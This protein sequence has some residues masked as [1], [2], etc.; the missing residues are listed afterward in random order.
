MAELNKLI[1]RSIANELFIPQNYKVYPTLINN[2]LWGSLDN[3]SSLVDTGNIKKLNI[4]KV[5]GIHYNDEIKSIS[6][7]NNQTSFNTINALRN[8]SI[9]YTNVLS[10]IDTSLEYIPEH[11]HIL[12]QIENIERM[13]KEYSSKLNMINYLVDELFDVNYATNMYMVGKETRIYPV[14]NKLVSSD[15]RI[16]GYIKVEGADD[17][18]TLNLIF[19]GIPVRMRRTLTSEYPGGLKN[20]IFTYP[21]YMLDNIDLIQAIQYIEINDQGASASFWYGTT[22]DFTLTDFTGFE[23]RLANLHTINKDGRNLNSQVD[24]PQVETNI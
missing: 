10:T 5:V 24:P 16:S 7:I 23:G 20:Y 8:S 3:Q 21:Q 19:R 13:E 14:N 22:Y 4:N 6:E 12:E 18:I 17:T 15:T 1:V 2:P 11:F 9:S